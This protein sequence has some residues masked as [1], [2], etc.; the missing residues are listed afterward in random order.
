MAILSMLAA[1]ALQDATAGMLCVAEREVDGRTY[2]LQR[3]TNGP[4][5][6]KLSMWVNWTSGPL[7][8]RR[9][10]EWG[11]RGQ[12]GELP[13]ATP[14]WIEFS[15]PVS[16]PVPASADRARYFLR[17]RWPD[18]TERR[19]SNNPWQT[20]RRTFVSMQPSPPTLTFNSSNPDLNR[21]LV[22]ARTIHAV[23][24]DR[25]GRVLGEADLDFPD[26][27]EPVRMAALLMPEAEAML[28]R[29][30]TPENRQH[31]RWWEITP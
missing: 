30:Y 2:R 12:T 31:C 17:I 22:A 23:A 7:Q 13:P 3:A 27:E 20:G 8:I 16:S 9:L 21:A 29:S 10:I 15:V 1:L 25:H 26:P 28:D 14:S 6:V 11:D 18:G 4:H 19:L 5:H 24:E